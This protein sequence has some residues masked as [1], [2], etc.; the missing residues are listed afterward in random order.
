MKL[1]RRCT[2]GLLATALTLSGVLTINL[3]TAHAVAAN[4][5]WTGASS[6][7]FNTAGNWSSCNS[8]VPQ[9]GDNLVFNVSSLS[10]NTTLTNNI[11][12]LSV[13]TI[14]FTGTNANSYTYTIAGNAMTVSGNMSVVS[15]YPTI[16]VNLT[17]GANLA[18][19]GTGL[20]LGDGSNAPALAMNS[21]NLTLGTG[22]DTPTVYSFGTITGSGNISLLQGANYYPHDNSGWTGALSIANGASA[23]IASEEGMGTSSST[24]TIASGG[25]LGL[26][27]LEGASLPQN[28]TVAGV[29]N[30]TSGAIGAFVSCG[31]NSGNSTTPA[32]VTL[33]GTLTLTAN[34]TI[35]S[36]DT[37]TISGPVS[38][39]YTISI[40]DTSTGTIVLSS[41]NNTSQTSNGTL[42]PTQQTVSYSADSPATTIT[43]PA[44]TVATVDGTYGDTSVDN[45]GV[46][47]GTG[48]VGAL[49]VL[50]GGIVAPGHSPGCLSS[51]DLTLPGT[52]QAEIGG[53]TVCSGYDQ[54]RVTG[55]VTL[56]DGT[57]T[58]SLYDNF[59]PAAGQTYT[60]ISN[61]GSDAVSGTFAGLAQGATF[62]LETTVFRI[63]YQGGDGND[64]VLTVVSGPGTPD[65]GFALAAAHPAQT[66]AISAAAALLIVALA[67][68]QARKFST[69]KAVRRRR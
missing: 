14:S 46:L 41:S 58:T 63:S 49:T 24:V 20:F 33:T 28:I 31:M 39:A 15:G 26:C 67:R 36:A 68:T 3:G 16:N 61:D 17:L 21:H 18:I 1:L 30:G 53:T 10:A 66:L 42:T 55:T 48:T 11:S 34:T 56:T 44:N 50:A 59:K 22:S 38:G 57:L 29:G 64:V 47:K 9:T 51:G 7:N 43:V 45:G 40:A 32:Q 25:Y 23:L 19:T 4:C 35:F 5:T 13:G 65:S 2:S 69:A 54:L 60:I 37:T 62:T 52:Y 8:T 12:S 6:N 27:G